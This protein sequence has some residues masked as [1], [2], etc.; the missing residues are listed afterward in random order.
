MPAGGGSGGGGL[1]DD[2]DDMAGGAPSVLLTR[3]SPV[4]KHGKSLGGDPAGEA[5]K[6]S[7]PECGQAVEVSADHSPESPDEYNR[8]AASNPSP[9]APGKPELLFVYDTIAATKMS[10][11][12]IFAPNAKGQVV[13]TGAG[14][15]YK[16][17][18]NE[19]ATLV[20]T[21]PY[22]MFQDALAFTRS[23]GDL[24]LQT[25]GVSHVPEVHWFDLPDPSSRGKDSHGVL[26]LVACSDGVWDNWVFS[27]VSQF[28]LDDARTAAML[29]S[30]HAQAAAEE[31]MA[32]NKV[33]AR[34]NFGSSADNM[35]ACVA[36]FVPNK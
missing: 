7:H 34:R 4:W 33:R 30:P 32:A 31:L 20:S 12:A 8:I 6:S 26:G 13:V 17:V 36:Y 10:C 23:L 3:E 14:T 35:T 18:R 27:D 19:W 1:A 22:A 28:M 25:Y 15:Y 21:P 5:P 16:N 29:S 9:D 2:D 24:H 11:P